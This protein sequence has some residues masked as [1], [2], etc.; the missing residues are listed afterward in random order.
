MASGVVTVDL[1][2][3]EAEDVYIL[4]ALLSASMADAV[5]AGCV[6]EAEFHDELVGLSNVREQLKS[7]EHRK[8]D[9][10]TIPPDIFRR[11]RLSRAEA[12]LFSTV[13]SVSGECLDSVASILYCRYTKIGYEIE[14]LIDE[15]LGIDRTARP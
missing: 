7:E 15:V 11:V 5:A 14:K 4:T 12:E 8:R 6:T 3:A 1:N 9:Y 13:C 2:E 10:T